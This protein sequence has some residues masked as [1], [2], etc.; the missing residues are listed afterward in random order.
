MNVQLHRL[1]D[2]LDLFVCIRSY[3]SILLQE[4]H[5]KIICLIQFREENWHPD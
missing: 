5:V 4:K 1:S 3:F 2:V